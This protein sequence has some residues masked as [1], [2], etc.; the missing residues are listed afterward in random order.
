MDP[1]FC[2]RMHAHACACMRAHVN[3]DRM[4]TW[5]IGKVSKK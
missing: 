3:M 2:M 4:E 1:I 5:K